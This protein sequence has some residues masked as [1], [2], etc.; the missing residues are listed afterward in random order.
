MQLFNFQII[1]LQYW[2]YYLYLVTFK[3]QTKK[4]KVK[5]QLI[6]ANDLYSKLRKNLGDKNCELEPKHISKLWN[7]F[8]I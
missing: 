5:V 2:N 3:Q 8:K 4:E 1:F 7:L 6:D